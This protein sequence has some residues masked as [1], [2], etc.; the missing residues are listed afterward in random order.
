M[1]LEDIRKRLL[2]KCSEWEEDSKVSEDFRSEFFNLV[3]GCTYLLMEQKENF[4]AHFLIQLKREIKIQIKTAIVSFPSGSYFTLYF[5]PIIFL[6][7]TIEEMCALLKHE[8]YHIISLHH[9]RAKNLLLKYSEEAVSTAMDISVNQYIINLP[10]WSEKLEN[11]RFAY[12]VDLK[13]EDTIEKYAELIQEAINRKQIKNRSSKNKLI[14]EEGVEEDSFYSIEKAHELWKYSEFQQEDA[15]IKEI[16]KKLASGA[17]RGALPESIAKLAASLNSKS[18][19]NWSGYLK[20]LIGTIPSGSK[21]TITRKNRRQPERFDMRG[22]L[23]KQIVHLIV[24]VDISGSMSD[25]EIE[26]I[27]TE[28]IS[29]V[30]NYHY[31]ITIIECDS[32]IRR[33]YDVEKLKDLKQKLNTKGGTR[34]FPVFDYM[35]SNRLK[36][37]LLIYFTDGKGERELSVDRIHRRVL[38]VLTGTELE[39]SLEVPPGVV[40]RLKNE[41]KK[42]E[43]I[44]ALEY[45]KSELKEIRSEW[46]K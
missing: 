18:Q 13:E 6:S 43:S 36:D 26:K 38:W 19:L 7:C 5:N 45:L 31:R 35:N 20:R 44:L 24:A 27:M 30:K 12:N 29:I 11:A 15:Q 16:V 14:T 22:T 40:L 42:E 25:K 2:K 41:V 1:V 3:E 4:F 9:I 23:N 37:S 34:Y 10:L 46:A 17:N 33:V 28:I 32:E 8:V 21:K 39:L